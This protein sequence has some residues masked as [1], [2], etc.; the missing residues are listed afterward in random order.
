[1]QST[2]PQLDDFV[3]IDIIRTIRNEL[4]KDFLDERHLKEYFGHRFNIAELS[5]VK[6][7]FIKRDLKK[8]LID[9]VDTVHYQPLILEIRETGVASLEQ[10]NDQFFYLELDTIFKQYTF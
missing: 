3:T 4:I 7:E 6:V 10:G 9:P 5:R 1:M 8:L 2:T